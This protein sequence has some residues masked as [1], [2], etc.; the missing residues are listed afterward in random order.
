MKIICEDIVGKKKEY[1]I[2]YKQSQRTDISFEEEK[3]R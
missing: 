1:S 3:W 2:P